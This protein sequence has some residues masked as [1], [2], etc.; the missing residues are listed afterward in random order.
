[1]ALLGALAGGD[2]VALFLD[3]DG[4]LL[5]I[6]LT[7]DAVEVSDALRR[8]LQRT[9]ASLNGALA[10]VS[11]RSIAD[12]D[13]LFAPAIFP[14]A[15]QHGLER[16]TATGAIV[17]PE[18]N[19]EM[20]Q[21][22]RR[23]LAELQARHSGLLLEDKG[24]SLAMHYRQAAHCEA[25][26]SDV[27]SKLL[28]PLAGRYKLIAGKYVLELAP[29]DYS[30]RT[31]IEGFMSEAPFRGRMPVFIGDDITDEEGFRAVNAQGG[32]SVRVGRRRPTHARY[33]LK[34][35]TAVMAWLNDT[36]RGETRSDARL[37]TKLS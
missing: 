35:V 9:A 3:V 21:P 34:D 19:L 6:A 5:E 31:A 13:R 7:P 25:L 16:R 12:L 28:L 33:R 36:D 4:T 20:L 10:L 30:K 8:T 27:M 11:G 29:K 15:G 18:M 14:A 22:V 37:T 2:N 26:V 32:Y 24:A 23:A 17:R 1:M